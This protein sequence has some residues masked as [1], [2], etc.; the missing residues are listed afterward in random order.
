[1]SEHTCAKV[2]IKLSIIYHASYMSDCLSNSVLVSIYPSIY[3]SPFF[4]IFIRTY[5]IH[6]RVFISICI[7]FCPSILVHLSINVHPF[8]RPSMI[9]FVFYFLCS[10]SIFGFC[11]FMG[12]FIHTFVSFTYHNI[13]IDS[14]LATAGSRGLR[15]LG[16][17]GF[18][19]I[20]QRNWSNRVGTW[21]RLQVVM[22][23][24][25]YLVVV[26]NILKIFTPIWGRFPI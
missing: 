5:Y 2:P 1:M 16:V 25:Y 19:G 3:L 18:G 20:S 15:R 9:L 21:C 26:S 10:C 4:K 6:D 7:H 12:C 17:H 22:R 11:C 23:N 8:I 14:N 24:K 13:H